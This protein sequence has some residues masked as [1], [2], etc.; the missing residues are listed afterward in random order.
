MK[1]RLRFVKRSGQ[2]GTLSFLLAGTLAAAPAPPKNT[3]PQPAK[4]EAGQQQEAPQSVFAIPNTPKEGRD[5]FYPASERVYVNKTII[6]TP[7]K[8]NNAPVNLIVNGIIPGE[9]P[10]V[11]INGRTFAPGESADVSEK[12]GRRTRVTCVEIK[13]DSIIIEANG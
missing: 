1:A 3:A 9:K 2:V 8:T 10:L 4:P 11:M 5:P 6:P 7:S 13:S 12:D